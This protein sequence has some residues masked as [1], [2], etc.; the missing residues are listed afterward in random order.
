VSALKAAPFSLEWGTSVFVKVAALN[1]YGA[2]LDSEAGNGAII[3]TYPD[4]PENLAEDLAQ[5]T[6]T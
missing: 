5:K 4:P 3:T 2:S 6:S 1:T